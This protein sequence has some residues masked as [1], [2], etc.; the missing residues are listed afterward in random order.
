VDRLWNESPKYLQGQG[1][2]VAVVDSGIE[3]TSDLYTVMGQLR[4]AASINVNN[5]Y[6]QNI[7]DQAGRWGSMLPAVWNC[8][9]QVRSSTTRAPQP[10]STS[11][12]EGVC[13]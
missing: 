12:P 7:F 9:C 1:V 13:R 2:G 5:G 10:Y 11:N 4:V 6:N 8:T 3:Y